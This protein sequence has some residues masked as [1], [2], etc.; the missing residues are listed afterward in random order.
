MMKI[1]NLIKEN[2][3]LNKKIWEIWQEK[4]RLEKINK[5]LIIGD[6]GI[7]I[8]TFLYMIIRI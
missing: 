4:E 3:L 5:I 8:V 1:N 2:D 6:I 7:I